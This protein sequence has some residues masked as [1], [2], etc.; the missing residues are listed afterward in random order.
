MLSCFTPCYYYHTYVFNMLYCVYKGFDVEH[1]A[2]EDVRSESNLGAMLP[3]LYRRERRQAVLPVRSKPSGH[4]QHYAEGPNI[5]DMIVCACFWKMELEWSKSK[6]R[7]DYEGRDESVDAAGRI[8]LE[9]VTTFG[10]VY[11]VHWSLFRR[12]KLFCCV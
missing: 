5:R 2:Q 12:I 3:L 9:Q 8:D 7:E 10:S 6:H 4:K 11:Y 1:S